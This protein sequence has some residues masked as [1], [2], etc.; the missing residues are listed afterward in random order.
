MLVKEIM[1]KKPDYISP[2]ITLKEAASEMLKRD[3]GFLPVGDKDKDRLIGAITDRDIAIRA[4]AK[5]KDPSNTHVNEVMTEH[6]RTCFE[7]ANVKDV[8]KLMSDLKIR[9]LVVLNR[10]KRMTGIL[11][12]GDL[13]TKANNDQLIG[14]ILHDL[15]EEIE[16]KH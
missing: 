7:D 4:V 3:I 10:N 14:H 6:I 8:A 11:T 5:G 16:T 13:A 12:L 15:C 1:S 2:H 9:R